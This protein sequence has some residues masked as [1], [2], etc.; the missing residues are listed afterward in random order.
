[1]VKLMPKHSYKKVNRRIWPQS[2]V[3]KADRPG[4]PTRHDFPRAL[5]GFWQSNP[6]GMNICLEPDPA[7]RLARG[8]DPRKASIFALSR[9]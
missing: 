2:N 6:S 4:D 7:G 3:A 1:M 9:Q 5:V 8:L